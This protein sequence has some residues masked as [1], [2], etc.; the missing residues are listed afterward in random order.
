VSQPKSVHN[1]RSLPIWFHHRGSKMEFVV[2]DEN[3]VNIRSKAA[4]LLIRRSLVGVDYLVEWNIDHDPGFTK[5]NVWM[6]ESELASA[7]G[8]SDNMGDFGE[9][10]IARFGGTT[11]AE[12]KF[13]RYKKFLN[14]PCP[15]TGNDGDPNISIMINNNIRE[16]IRHIFFVRS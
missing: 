16:A 12:G 8:L 13:I 1:A 15:G 10:L 5:G 9:W 6:T 14:V 3:T 11:A 2:Q 7:F 4:S